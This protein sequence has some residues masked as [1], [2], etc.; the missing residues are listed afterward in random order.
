M[1]A[2]NGRPQA[3]EDRGLH[4]AFQAELAEKL[5]VVMKERDE[6]A[7]ALKVR[8]GEL[9]TLKLTP[10]TPVP[11]ANP[12][13]DQRELDRRG[14][15]VGARTS[16]Q[17]SVPTSWPRRRDGTLRS[18][19]RRSKSSIRVAIAAATGPHASGPAA[20]APVVPP[21]GIAPAEADTRPAHTQD[22]CRPQRQ[23]KDQHPPRAA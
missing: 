14:V 18:G 6:L 5:G 4:T 19:R 15:N 2:S 11:R 7:N 9:K 1:R 12:P 3:A 21:L 20:C 10:S 8:E 22:M 16:R 13:S 23:Y 17:R